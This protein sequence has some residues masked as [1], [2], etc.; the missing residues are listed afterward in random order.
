MR[1][2]FCALDAPSPVLVV[3]AVPESLTDAERTT[4]VLSALRSTPPSTAHG[5]SAP[6]HALCT[7]GPTF[8]V[9]RLDQDALAL[10]ADLT[11]ERATPAM[12]ADGMMDGTTPA[13]VRFA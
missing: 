13:S 1:A 11:V 10:V 9:F 2:A 7:D 12:Y 5:T 4:C 8:S 3:L 6:L